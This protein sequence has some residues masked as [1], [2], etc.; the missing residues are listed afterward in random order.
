MLRREKV[1]RK[2]STCERFVSDERG[3]T[4]IEYALIAALIASAIV[5]SLNLVGGSLKGALNEVVTG[6]TS[7]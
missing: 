3:A 5:A 6:F 7:L 2:F 4:A 1:L